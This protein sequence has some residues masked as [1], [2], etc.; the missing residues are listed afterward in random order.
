MTGNNKSLNLGDSSAEHNTQLNN[1]VITLL[2]TICWIGLFLSTFEA[3]VEIWSRSETFAHGFLIFPIVIWLF[4]RDRQQFTALVINSSIKG[5][6]VTV[7]F[8][9]LW[10]SG[11]LLDIAVFSQLGA[12]GGLAACHWMVFGDK[13][14][15]K[16][17][18][19]LVYLIFAVPMGNTL[20][21]MLQTITAELTVFMLEL[22]QVPVYFEGLY[23][24]TPTGHFEVAVACSGIR[25]LI[26]SL[27]VG[28]LFAYLNYRKL[29]KQ[30]TFV[31]F[32]IAVP[33]LANGIRAYLIVLIAHLSDMKYA[34]GVDHLIYGW[35]FF[36]LVISIMFYIGARFSDQPADQVSQATNQPN[37]YFSF[38]NTSAVIVI[39]VSAIIIDFKIVTVSPPE[40]SLL[41]V[42]PNLVNFTQT[43]NVGWKPKFDYALAEYRGDSQDG[44]E[45][46]IAQFA[47]RQTQGELITSSNRFFNRH[48]WTQLSQRTGQQ[49]NITYNELELSNINGQHR[50]IRYWYHIDGV[51]ITSLPIIKARQVWLALTNPT[52]RVY[53]F[54]ISTLYQGDED[55]Y[56]QAQQRLIQVMEHSSFEL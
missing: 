10:L 50:L 49:G 12:V 40:K 44:V 51:E 24:T 17:Q 11:Q 21:P 22:S 41:F 34:T 9:M 37:S 29:S 30:I 27:A 55:T 32:S 31:L 45:L 54:A 47:S 3:T 56:D 14:A 33:I 52:Q 20:I 19:P 8:I 23:I 1:V 28:T 2:I 26:A 13:F 43:T 6:V 18:F 46:Y 25:Y 38:T 15:K 5:A 48:Y 53:V 4:W 35:L 42:A 7:L 39:A 16:Y 36:G